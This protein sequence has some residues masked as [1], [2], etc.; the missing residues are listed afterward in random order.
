MT[1]SLYQTQSQPLAWWA[2]SCPPSDIHNV[3][4]LRSPWILAFRHVYIQK[5]LIEVLQ[6]NRWW[7]LTFKRPRTDAQKNRTQPAIIA[8]R[9]LETSGT[10]QPC[11][12]KSWYLSFQLLHTVQIELS[13]FWHLLC[14]KCTTWKSVSKSLLTI[15][16]NELPTSIFE[17]HDSLFSNCWHT[18]LDA[19]VQFLGRSKFTLGL[20]QSEETDFGLQN[21]CRR[22][23]SAI[24]FGVSKIFMGPKIYFRTSSHYFYLSWVPSK[25]LF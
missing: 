17:C 9:K 21:G 16:R 18:F 8:E 23:I 25:T 12:Q 24:V 10:Q 3:L 20:S 14:R 15:R 4:T 5:R 1:F 2:L 11:G 7:P 22:F 6:W 13:I 19:G